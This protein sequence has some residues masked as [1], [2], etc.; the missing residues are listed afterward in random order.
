MAKLRE[1]QRAQRRKMIALAKKR[2]RLLERRVLLRQRAMQARLQAMTRKEARLRMLQFRIKARQKNTTFQLSKTRKIL[3]TISQQMSYYRRI[4]RN[5]ILKRLQVLRRFQMKKASRLRLRWF[6][7]QRQTADVRRR[8][9][10]LALRKKRTARRMREYQNNVKAWFKKQ[11]QKLTTFVVRTR[12]SRTG[13]KREEILSKKLSSKKTKKPPR[14]VEGTAL[15]IP[16]LFWSF[17]D[18]AGG[19]SHDAIHKTVARFLGGAKV[20]STSARGHVASPSTARGWISLGDY[21]GKCFSD[22]SKCKHNGMTM[23][24]SLKLNKRNLHKKF[25]SYF[26]SSG[27]QTTQARGFA[28]LHL[29]NRYIIILSTHNKQWKIETR[30]LP[31]G[32]MNVAF[33][34]KNDDL[35]KMY[36]NG[37]EVARGKAVTVSR[38]KDAFTTLEIGRPNNSH[39]PHFRIPL[40]IDNFVLWERSLTSEEIKA[41]AKKDA[42]K[43]A[44]RDTK[45]E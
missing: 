18:S 32:W 26:L 44:L 16:D 36:V 33:T 27:G 8:Q 39:S 11:Q 20:V 23:M 31:Q 12:T 7:Y 41:L 43:P 34:W 13:K 6:R 10:L 35:L 15:K 37:K 24:T 22:P 42:G 29:A 19:V 30:N 45:K 21:K 5:Y 25:S 1:R 17:E 14:A 38:A 40:E 9:R 4:R 28:F 2:M 3:I